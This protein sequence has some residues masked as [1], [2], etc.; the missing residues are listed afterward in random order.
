[1]TTLIPKFDL[2]DGGATPTGAINRTIYE[3]LSD[4][5]S[6]KD[7]G[8]IGDG[9]TDDT[10]AIQ[11]A[12]DAKASIYI[13]D[14]TYKLTSTIYTRI[15]R[16]T[17]TFGAQAYLS[18]AHNN[19]SGIEV[20]EEWL[21]LNGANI[22]NHAGF[23]QSSNNGVNR[24][25][26]AK[27]YYIALNGGFLQ[28]KYTPYMIYFEA[29]NASPLV[30]SGVSIINGV[31]FDGL[32][33]SNNICLYYA[34]QSNV[35]RI[36]NCYITNYVYGVV[37][38]GNMPSFNF[39]STAFEGVSYPFTF[40]STSRHETGFLASK[41]DTCYFENFRYGLTFA[42]GDVYNL[43]VSNCYFSGD[44][45]ADSK[46]V[47]VSDTAGTGWLRNLVFNNNWY[48]NV[49]TAYNLGTSLIQR[50]N[51]SVK[52]NT[53]DATVSV[54][55]SGDF[56]EVALPTYDNPPVYDFLTYAGTYPAGINV[57]ENYNQAMVT[58]SYAGGL[59]NYTLPTLGS[60]YNTVG[61][62]GMKLTFTRVAGYAMR[63]Y[64][65]ASS[66]IGNSATGK[67][68]ELGSNGASLTIE[69]TSPNYWTVVS[70]NG[71]INVEP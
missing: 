25:I 34:E 60:V 16:Q 3:K 57:D 26:Y 56:K 69:C 48:Q 22:I 58:N 67:Y 23:N 59:I 15:V 39:L 53:V 42:Y 7:F 10:V 68:Y 12:L 63:V 9:T 62:L 47:Q 37:T 20:Q 18:L 28:G 44:S 17:I 46:I 24:F 21:T 40:N 11:A 61:W 70:S 31:R 50:N 54:Y 2:K 41:I 43:T 64:P 19:T 6:V 5:V 8:A 55:S 45:N 1:M 4:A 30:F 36:Q 71:T 32:Q 65:D 13:P 14:G 33:Q 35:Q 49:N 38:D 27:S 66:K 51:W 52:N 29:Y